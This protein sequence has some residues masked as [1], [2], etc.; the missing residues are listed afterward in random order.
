V[1]TVEPLAKMKRI[2]G[3]DKPKMARVT[4]ISRDVSVG[5]T[6]VLEV[7]KTIL[8]VVSVLI[9]IVCAV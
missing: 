8:S 4:N 1:S 5:P 9:V 2:F 7:R 6:A 3:R